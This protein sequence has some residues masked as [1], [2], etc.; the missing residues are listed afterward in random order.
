[1][2][3][4]FD[5]LI[6][7]RGIQGKD[8]P[9]S[10]YFLNDLPGITTQKLEDISDLEDH[11]EPR[12]V[13]D[14]VFNVSVRKIET[15][16]KRFMRPYYNN[17]E[18]QSNATTGQIDVDNTNLAAEAFYSGWEFDMVG[19]AIDKSVV[20]ESITMN[21]VSGAA[22]FDLKVFDAITG[23]TLKTISFVVATGMN[24]YRIL[25]T[26]PIWKHRRI[27]VGYDA[28]NLVV[29]KVDRFDRN[30]GTTT[31]G[32]VATSASATFNNITGADTGMML[33]YNIECSIDNFVCHRT[34]LFTDP[35][36]YKMGIEFLTELL[37]SDRV[38]RW[39]LLDMEDAKIL[40]DEFIETYDKMMDD[41]FKD[42]RVDINTECFRCAKAVTYEVAIP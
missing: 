11:Y 20:L 39:T 7:L 30:I 18:Y 36:L 16:I 35:F 37:F 41:I 4:C 22:T 40:R 17:Y 31:A 15:D 19:T 38:N 42:I 6:G 33:A 2:I 1:M 34:D 13:F 21:I 9:D 24:T 28:T 23:E 29:K 25:F 8:F 27:F 3:T 32:H 14:D 26:A 10:G 12:L 5:N